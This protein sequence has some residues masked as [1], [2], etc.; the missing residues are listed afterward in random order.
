[1]INEKTFEIKK[2]NDIQINI[3]EKNY[4]NKNLQGYNNI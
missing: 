4:E 1:M 3:E 2:D